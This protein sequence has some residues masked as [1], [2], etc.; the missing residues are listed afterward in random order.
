MTHWQEIIRKLIAPRHRVRVGV[1][2]KYI[3]LQDAYKSV[4]ESIT[5]GGIAN[6]CKVNI[7]RIDAE[8]AGDAVP[9]DRQHGVE[10]QGEQRG[11]E[12][13]RR[14]ALAEGA[15]ADDDRGLVR[16]A[17]GQTFEDVSDRGPFPPVDGAPPAQITHHLLTVTPAERAAVVAAL[18]SGEARSRWDLR[19]WQS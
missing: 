7:R 11:Q 3:G 13:E 16:V 12:A 8:D 1:V 19:F 17:P 18:A 5:H 14:K 10:R 2:G 4:Y 15:L 6:N 9:E